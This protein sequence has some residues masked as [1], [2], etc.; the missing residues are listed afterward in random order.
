MVCR[1]QKDWYEKEE[2]EKIKIYHNSLKPT[3]GTYIVSREPMP[4][5]KAV[6]SGRIVFH[7]L[8]VG[9]DQSKLEAYY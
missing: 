8:T 3:L 4:E 9:F 6:E 1:E 2:L 7:I 5:L